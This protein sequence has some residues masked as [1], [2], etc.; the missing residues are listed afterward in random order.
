[1]KCRYGLLGGSELKLAV[2]EGPIERMRGLLGRPLPLGQG[3]L[4]RPCN[5][6]HTWGMRY[7]IDVVF[8]SRQGV[9]LKLCPDVARKRFR[10]CLGAH[11]VIELPAGDSLARCL[12]R[13]MAVARELLE[14]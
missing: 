12:R 14:P 5:M 3:L 13:G 9:I 6:V 10:G 11:A 7:P 8:V 4:I 1:M 2:T